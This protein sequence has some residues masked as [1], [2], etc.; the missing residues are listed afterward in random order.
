[1]N[2]LLTH[3]I[4]V[5]MLSMIACTSEFNLN[6][7]AFFIFLNHTDKLYSE[8]GPVS[9]YGVLQGQP[10]VPEVWVPGLGLLC[11][12]GPATEILLLSGFPSVKGWDFSSAV[13]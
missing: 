2:F 11:A 10:G 3:F 8:S 13:K 6:F 7:L 4:S 5:N 1:M 9:Q 12:H